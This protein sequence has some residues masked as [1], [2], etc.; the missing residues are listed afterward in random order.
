MGGTTRLAHEPHDVI[1]ADATHPAAGDSWPLYTAD[2]YRIV[3]SRLRPNGIFAKWLPLHNMNE[4]DFLGVMK[5][6]RGAF[7][8]MLVLFANRSCVL[9]GAASPLSL[10]AD[11]LTE[12]IRKDAKIAEDLKPY[13]IERGEDLLK[14][15]VLDGPA[16]DRLTAQA[17]VLTDDRASVEFAELRRIGIAETFPLT[18]RPGEGT[19]PSA[20]ARR[21]DRP[22]VFQARKAPRGA[23]RAPPADARGD[24]RGARQ[25]GRGG[26]PRDADVEVALETM[27][28]DLLRRISEDYTKILE[29]DD[30]ERYVEIF[31][32]AEQLHPDD[33]FLNQ[34]LGATFLRLKRWKDAVPYLE[35]A[36]EARPNDVNYQSN[37]V[38]A[39]E[40]SGRYADALDALA[41]LRALEPTMAELD[42]VQQRIEQE[43][44]GKREGS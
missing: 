40:Q 22:A 29:R 5:T 16:V 37:L 8:E 13:G 7:P 19:D 25:L 11:V 41:R 21:T 1:A 36:A 26:L 10:D 2:Y 3:R 6:F 43:R 15:L 32:Y 23:A 28:A 31:Y 14:Y 20:L 24:L 42:R 27:Q 4:A 9:I 18:R 12:R 44:A 30:L 39:Y 35:R 17:D 34:L 33:P 38:F